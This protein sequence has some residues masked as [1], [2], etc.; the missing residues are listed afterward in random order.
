ME[1]ISTGDNG[2]DE[3][4]DSVETVNGGD[5]S[6]EIVNGGDGGGSEELTELESSG[7]FRLFPLES[8][9]SLVK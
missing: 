3:S 2:G 9:T 6:G 5:D 7:S 4:D 1:K 8:L